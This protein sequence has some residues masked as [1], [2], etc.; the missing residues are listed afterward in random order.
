MGSIQHRFDAKVE[1]I[2]F[3]SCHVWTGAVN[4]FGYGKLGNGNGWVFAHR[5][6]YQQAK[7]EIP[8]G[9]YVLHTCDNPWC[10]NPDHLYLGTYKDNAKDREFRNRGNH[11]FGARHG[12]SKLTPDQVIEIRKLSA[13]EN[14]TCSELGRRFGINHK[15]V[16]DIVTRKHWSHI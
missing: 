2:P 9:K 6:S 3:A 16:Q 15:S 11:A 4:K 14:L 13:E 5:F 12:R 10:V 1:R 8:E 7:G